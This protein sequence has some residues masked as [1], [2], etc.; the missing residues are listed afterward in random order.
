MNDGK[1]APPSPGRP[2]ALRAGGA[3]LDAALIV[4]GCA[5]RAR[6]GESLAAALLAGGVAMLRRSPTAG[7]PRGAFC[8]MGVCQECMVHV[9]GRRVQA[10]LTPVRDGM[11]VSLGDGS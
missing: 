5:L 11:T 9:D 8:M 4:D 3:A 6:T 10:C 1:N 7:G 2:G